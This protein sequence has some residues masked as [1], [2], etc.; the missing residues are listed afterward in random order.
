ML[1]TIEIILIILWLLGVIT[2]HTI[3]GFIYIL[4]IIAIIMILILLIRGENPMK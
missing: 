1:Y 3:G 2:S 4:L